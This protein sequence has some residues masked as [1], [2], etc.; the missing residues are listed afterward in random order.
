LPKAELLRKSPHFT[1][2]PS[3]T[4]TPQKND[5]LPT[6][7]RLIQLKRTLAIYFAQQSAYVALFLNVEVCSFPQTLDD[8]LLA[9]CTSVDVLDVIYILD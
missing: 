4:S 6:R 1:L 3:T 5:M 2:N 8:Q 7:P 9:L